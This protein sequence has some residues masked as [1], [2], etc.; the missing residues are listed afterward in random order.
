M[1]DLVEADQ[2]H[3]YLNTHK[4]SFFLPPKSW[5]EAPQVR[6]EWRAIR[7]SGTLRA[8]VPRA[9]GVYTLLIQPGIFWHPN[10]SYLAYAGSSENLRDRFGAY[11]TKERRVRPK[12]R[13]LLKKWAGF[14]Y[15][16]FAESK[17]NDLERLEDALIQHYIPPFN[18]K[19]KGSLKRAVGAF[20]P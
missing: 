17:G 11:L 2:L 12:V 8:N 15:F 18:S 5:R 4:L 16:C 3:D 14:V 19:F 20:T 10:C 1:S 6:F 7:L 9:P 13:K